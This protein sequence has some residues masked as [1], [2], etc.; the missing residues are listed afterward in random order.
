[1]SEA[2]TQTRAASPAFGPLHIFLRGLA[3]FISGVFNDLEIEGTE[4][5]PASGA[6]ILASNH[7]SYLDPIFI[8]CGLERPVR[9]LAWERPFRIPVLGW[10]LRQYGAIPVVIE[11]PG[12]GSFEAAVKVLKDGEV[13]GIFPEG[14]RSQFGPMNPVKSGVAR[15]AMIS[16]API[17]PVTVQGAFRVWPK[18][19]LLPVPGRVRVTFHPPVRLDP[20][21]L[22][23][24]RRDR[25]Y[26]QEIVERVL[27][28]INS[29]LLPSLRAER[30]GEELMTRTELPM[31]F[32]VEGL[33]YF[34]LGAAAFWTRW[35]LYPAVWA[36]AFY[37]LYLAADIF[38]LP[39]GRWTLAFRNFSPWLAALGIGGACGALSRGPVF[40]WTVVALCAGLFWLQAFRFGA[41]RAVRIWGLAGL[42]LGF[43]YRGRL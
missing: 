17:V 5:V 6:V 7:P 26:E 32:A 34:F 11:K 21:E 23:E 29:A 24:R 20:G 40:A 18:H 39:R 4:H 33:P 28:S 15:L 14:G 2:G 12:R 16:G 1:M 19:K 42:Y 35:A 41:Y 38:L 13:F 27:R 30:R 9:F 3:A 10:L 36:A 43:L 37:S 8:M 31:S 22:Q 25:A